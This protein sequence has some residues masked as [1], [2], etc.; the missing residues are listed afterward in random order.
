M[1][2]GGDRNGAGQ[3]HPI[4]GLRPLC[5]LFIVAW[6]TFPSLI[7]RSPH[8]FLY[9]LLCFGPSV[10]LV[11]LPLVCRCRGWPVCGSPPSTISTSTQV[12]TRN[13]S[14]NDLSLVSCNL[15]RKKVN[16][17]DNIRR[18]TSSVR[19][20]K[21]QPDTKKGYDL[22]RLTSP[23]P[24]GFILPAQGSRGAPRDRCEISVEPVANQISEGLEG[25]MWGL[26]FHEPGCRVDAAARPCSRP[27]A[28]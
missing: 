16:C 28:V 9:F 23:T 17:T 2:L 4:N 10:N 12:P 20:Q 19:R 14:E 27:G 7:S 5:A 21:R 6:L 8:F 22:S 26:A 15:N 18:R 1:H 24:R 13:V 25:C 3:C 11:R